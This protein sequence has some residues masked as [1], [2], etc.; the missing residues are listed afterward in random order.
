[1]VI[2]GLS[3]AFHNYSVNSVLTVSISACKPSFT[4]V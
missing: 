3:R 2:L 4:E 1:M